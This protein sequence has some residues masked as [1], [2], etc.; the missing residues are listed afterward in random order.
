[1]SCPG[2]R[3]SIGKMG[4]SCCSFIGS[5]SNLSGTVFDESIQPTSVKFGRVG[6]AP[7]K[8]VADMVVADDEI[9]EELEIV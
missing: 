5:A 2:F 3:L 9:Q 4:T 8:V 1:M 7:C 6:F